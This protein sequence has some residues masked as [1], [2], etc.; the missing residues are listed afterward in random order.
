VSVK[1]GSNFF[2][3]TCKSAKV[4]EKCHTGAI[5]NDK[6]RGRSGNVF[7]H[8][9]FSLLQGTRHTESRPAVC[10]VH[11]NVCLVAYPLNNALHNPFSLV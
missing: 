8:G 10:A 1:Q 4:G 2:E 5:I 3:N 9:K 11:N 7:D 6:H